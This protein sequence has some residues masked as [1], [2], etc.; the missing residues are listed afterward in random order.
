MKEFNG[1]KTTS[2]IVFYSRSIL[3]PWLT[4]ELTKRKASYSSHRVRNITSSKKLLLLGT[5]SSVHLDHV[6]RK[7]V[8]LSP[9]YYQLHTEHDG[10]KITS[11][12]PFLPNLYVLLCYVRKLMVITV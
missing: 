6:D 3:V 2:K 11:T 9:S 8:T 12:I 1:V 5:N 7:H 10:T 4:G